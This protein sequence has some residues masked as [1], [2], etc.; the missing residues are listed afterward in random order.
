MVK[1]VRKNIIC[2][3][4][5]KDTQLL[6]SHNS[7]SV[8]LTELCFFSLRRLIQIAISMQNAKNDQY[9]RCS[10]ITELQL[11]VKNN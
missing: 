11:V 4:L 1:K 9:F 2:P 8:L 10:C 5:G 7:K 6:A 3:K